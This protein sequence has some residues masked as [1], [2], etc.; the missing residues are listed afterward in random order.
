MVKDVNIFFKEG[1][2]RCKHFQTP[3]CKVHTWQE[4]LEVLRGIA[5]KTELQEEMKWGFPCYTDRGKNIFSIAPFK[6]HCSINFFKGSLISTNSRVLI[7][8]GENSQSMRVVRFNNTQEIIALK[9]EILELIQKAI[10]VERK[11]LKIEKSKS[12]QLELPK[13]LIEIF[14]HDKEFL[15][16]FELLTPGRQRGYI[17][18]FSQAKQ[19]QTRFK[20]IE[21]NRMKIMLGKGLHD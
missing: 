12:N 1:C 13:E 3:T 8:S 16:K 10:L 21:N 20:R 11:G 5:L 18:Y 14:K 9:E 2:G 4:E 15:Q 17:L 6:N 7:S 19:T